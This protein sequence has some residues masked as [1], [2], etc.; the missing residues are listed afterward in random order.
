VGRWH[1]VKFLG[2]QSHSFTQKLHKNS[3]KFIKIQKKS[4]KREKN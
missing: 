2:N 4:E 1:L 3:N